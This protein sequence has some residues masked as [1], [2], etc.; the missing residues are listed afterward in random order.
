MPLFASLS[1][2]LG[3]A[4]VTSACGPDIAQ[5]FMEGGDN[6]PDA[7]MTFPDPPDAAGE[8]VDA[9]DAPNPMILGSSITG[10]RTED[11]FVQ[12]SWRVGGTQTATLQLRGLG[13][14]LSTGYYDLSECFNTLVSSGDIFDCQA[15]LWMY[16]PLGDGNAEQYIASEGILDVSQLDLGSMGAISLEMDSLVLTR[17]QKV[18][19]ANDYDT[20]P[21]P[22]TRV[23][24]D[25]PSIR[26][27]ALTPG[28]G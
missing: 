5:D 10:G 2:L 15:R 11:D 8:L 4:L 24:T 25:P 3:F 23:I 20:H 27:L 26:N 28:Q 17:V 18:D 1:I 16:H 21:E 12:I 9:C 7:G 13:Q 19:G 22:C 6:Q 14:P